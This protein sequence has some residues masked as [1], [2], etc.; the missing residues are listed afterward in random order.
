MYLFSGKTDM[1]N[2]SATMN[3]SYGLAC[4][5]YNPSVSLRLTV[6]APA[7]VGA[8][9]GTTGAPRPLAQGSLAGDTAI[10]RHKLTYK[11]NL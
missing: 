5:L 6:S 9:S 7:S 10:A 1:P 11:I 8:N 3:I 4:P 2:P